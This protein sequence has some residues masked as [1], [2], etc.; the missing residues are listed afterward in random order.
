M[1]RVHGT[2]YCLIFLCASAHIG[3]ASG[4]TFAAP[5]EAAKTQ[6]SDKKGLEVPNR[7]LPAVLDAKIEVRRDRTR[8]VVE[9]SDPF[10]LRIFTLINPNRVVIDMPEVLWRLNSPP[11][12]P[13]RGLI[14]SYRYGLFRSGD[15]RFVIDLNGPARVAEPVILPPQ[16]AQG[17]RLVVDLVP[18]DG[19]IFQRLSGWPPGLR[20]N[21]AIEQVMAGHIAASP[22]PSLHPV[23]ATEDPDVSKR[24]VVID[25][26]HGGI[27]SGA[28]GVDGTM[29]KV[30]V[31]DE[32]FRLRNVLANRGYAVHLTRESD[33]YIPLA[34]RVSIARGF[35]ADLLISLHADSNPDSSVSGASVYT[36]SESGSDKEA[37]AL[38][39]KENQSD[40]IAGV[41][42]PAQSSSVTSILIG[43]VQRETMNRANRFAEGAVEALSRTTDILQREPHRSAAFVVLKAADVPAVL[44]ELGYLSNARDCAQTRTNSWR[45]GVASAIADVVDR[46]FGTANAA[47]AVTTKQAAE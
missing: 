16:G 44:I 43:L 7:V 38:A 45:N 36:L 26:G 21:L 14:K 25:A 33:V 24:I 41:A 15:S 31:L 5:T 23:F 28:T 40:V 27:D 34:E 1:I 9:M 22:V 47:S 42:L 35:D 37:A 2:F 4:D 29:E 20:G 6:E 19:A 10:R 32:A 12:P 30:L 17:Y 46:Q 18:T 3:A 13:G 8:L 39:R 11:K